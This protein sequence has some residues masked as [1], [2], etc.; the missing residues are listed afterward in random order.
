MK[1]LFAV[2]V[3]SLFSFSVFAGSNGS[4]EMG[5]YVDCKLGDGSRDYIPSEICKM[6]DGKRMF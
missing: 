6:K 5:P 2:L 1:R 3:A 4:T